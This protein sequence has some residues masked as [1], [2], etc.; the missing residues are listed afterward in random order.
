MAGSGDGEG[1]DEGGGGPTQTRTLPLLYPCPNQQVGWGDN[2]DKFILRASSRSPEALRMYECLGRVMGC[3]V[4]TGSQLSLDL[5]ALVWK[6]LVG[7][8]VTGRDLAVIDKT[9][10]ATLDA[11]RSSDRPQFEAMVA[12]LGGLAYSTMLSDSTEVSLRGS[13]GGS[14]LVQFEDREAYA[15]MVVARRLTESDDQVRSQITNI[16]H[17][18]G[19]KF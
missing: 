6:G 5:P 16:I 12:Q 13:V 2:R 3:A 4:R 8:E 17:V 1:G 9:I 7:M 10:M 14:M 11:L 19:S 18:Y 15:R